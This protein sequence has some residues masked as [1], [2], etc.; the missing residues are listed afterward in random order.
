MHGDLQNRCM[1]DSPL[2]ACFAAATVANLTIFSLHWL[3]ACLGKMAK[4]FAPLA[5]HFLFV[6]IFLN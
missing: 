1:T 5:P 4:T 3:F 2:V 6:H